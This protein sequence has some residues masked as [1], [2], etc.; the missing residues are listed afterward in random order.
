MAI[1]V[2]KGYLV[3]NLV[4]GKVYRPAFLVKNTQMAKEDVQRTQSI[5]RI[6]V[7][8]ERCIRRVNENKLFENVIPLSMSGSIDQLFSVACLL[9]GSQQGGGALPAEHE[10]TVSYSC[11]GEEFSRTI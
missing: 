3:D 1:M 10:D 5:A 11:T 4:A 2:D 9:L 8:V 6:R 7:H